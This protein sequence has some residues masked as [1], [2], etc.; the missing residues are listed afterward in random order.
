V[1]WNHNTSL[2]SSK[3][4][5]GDVLHDNQGI[6]AI[7]Q[8]H[9]PS[10]SPELTAA[11]FFMGYLKAQ[12]FTHTLPDIHSLKNAVRQKIAN[13]TQDTLR[14]VMAS[15]PGRWQQCLDCHGG[16]LQDAVLKTRGFFCESKTLTYLTVFNCIYC[17][18]K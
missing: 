13:V 12:V 17:C 1:S 8:V 4:R 10:N 5:L 16:H 11:D 15:V 6:A 3:Q 18:V 7:S 14:R 2:A 9:L